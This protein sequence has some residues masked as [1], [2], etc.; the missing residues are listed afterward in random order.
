MADDLDTQDVHR[1]TAVAADRAGAHVV[2]ARR[3]LMLGAAAVL[4][5][6][7][8]LR[9]GAQAAAQ[10]FN[11]VS[12]QGVKNPPAMLNSMGI[13]RFTDAPDEWLRKKV[14]S[15]QAVRA[16][17]TVY[18]TTWDQPSVLAI[19]S[20]EKTSSGMAYKALLGTTW[21]PGGENDEPIKIG[22]PCPPWDPGKGA[23]LGSYCYS[24]SVENIG[25]SPDR[26]GLVYADETGLNLSLEPGPGMF[27]IR[28][29]C[30]ASIIGTRGTNLG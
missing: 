15:G 23:G 5:S 7:V 13:P 16:G 26:Y 6:V 11:C 9:S 22:P 14:F 25:A 24:E 4:P 17:S 2:T 12:R 1:P 21:S 3:R 19:A 8:T 18:C 20:L 30:F 10:S 27:P 28:E 29:T